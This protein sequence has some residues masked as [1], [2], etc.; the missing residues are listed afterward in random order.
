MESDN[1]N[2][3]LVE[4]GPN[5]RSNQVNNLDTEKLAQLKQSFLQFE[6]FFGYEYSQ[7]NQILYMPEEYNEQKPVDLS[8]GLHP[9]KFEHLS[10]GKKRMTLTDYRKFGLLVFIIISFLVKAAL[11]PGLSFFV[12]LV[13][14]FLAQ[15]NQYTNEPMKT[16]LSNNKL[17]EQ[18]IKE[19]F[20]Q[21]VKSMHE[22]VISSKEDDLKFKVKNSI[23]IT[24]YVDLTRPPPFYFQEQKRAH[25]LK[26]KFIKVKNNDSTVNNIV[27]VHFGLEQYYVIEKESEIFMSNYLK[28]AAQKFYLRNTEFYTTFEFLRKF[29]IKIYLSIVFL[30]FD[31]YIAFGKKDKYSIIQRKLLSFNRDL[32]TR[33]Y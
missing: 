19:I 30:V 24:G 15:F 5:D 23:D 22:M 32:N 13:L 21:R 9:T 7:K 11:S 20:T 28:N 12:I 2:Q 29:D 3:L 6:E 10:L 4:S 17:K 18:K 16:I 25:R 33:K 27:S 14:Y 26:D 31:F 1:L 8:K